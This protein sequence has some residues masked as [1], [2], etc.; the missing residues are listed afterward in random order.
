MAVFSWQQT[1]D[2]LVFSG[3]LTR[4]TVPQAWQ[5]RGQWQQGKQQLRVDLAQLEHVDSAGV[6]MLLQLKKH[7]LQNECELTILEP[8]QQFRAIV[9]VSGATDLLA[10]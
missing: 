9:D 5:E 3:E 10:I 4:E 2:Q 1:D 6:A 8:S 7:L